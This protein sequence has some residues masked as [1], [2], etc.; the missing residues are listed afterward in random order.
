[1]RDARIYP[2]FIYF[3]GRTNRAS[4][5]KIKNNH[6]GDEA[7]ETQKRLL[8]QAVLFD[9]DGSFAYCWSEWNKS[10]EER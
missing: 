9:V 1:M 10:K 3:T 8:M 2:I 7:G 5:K 4:I 6:N